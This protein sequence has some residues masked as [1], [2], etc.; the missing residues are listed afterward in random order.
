M[1]NVNP[2]MPGL[3]HSGGVRNVEMAWEQAAYQ[4]MPHFQPGLTIAG[5]QERQHFNTLEQLACRTVDEHPNAATEVQYYSLTMSR[6]PLGALM[7][8]SLGPQ[9]LPVNGRATVYG[10]NPAR[11][12]TYSR[13]SRE[14]L[15]RR[16]GLLLLVECGV[17]KL[18]GNPD[19]AELGQFRMELAYTP[20]LN[21]YGTHRVLRIVGGVDET[22]LPVLPS[23]PRRRATTSLS[24]QF[25]ASW[26]PAG[27]T[28]KKRGTHHKYDP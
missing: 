6:Q 12:A 17:R 14:T 25:P 2:I 5:L 7:L 3:V 20:E 13:A 10:W 28:S 16:R 15:E 9:L 23:I 27:R 11:V 26:Q 1:T 22:R 8:R 4:D 19:A 24:L 18:G 21:M